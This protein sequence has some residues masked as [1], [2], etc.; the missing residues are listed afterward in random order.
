M[1]SNVNSYVTRAE[2]KNNKV[3]LTVQVAGYKPGEAVEISG[4]ATQDNGA[5][6]TFYDIQNVPGTN[7]SGHSYLIVTA[8]PVDIAKFEKGQAAGKDIIVVARVAKVWATMLKKVRVNPE[9]P[10]PGDMAWE[11]YEAVPVK[12]G[13][14]PTPPWADPGYPAGSPA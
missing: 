14:S 12:A 13:T 9:D 10:N 1:P 2:L 8:N 6:A 4:H 11:A 3:V 7:T 5:F